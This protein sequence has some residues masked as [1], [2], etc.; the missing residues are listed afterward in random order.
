MKKVFDIILALN[1]VFLIGM[2][3]WHS[4]VN[5]TVQKKINALERKYE[6]LE[7]QKE[8]LK[9]RISNR[10]IKIDSLDSIKNLQNE[11]IIDSFNISNDSLR[12]LF[13]RTTS[14]R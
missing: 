9:K 4:I 8:N 6:R 10:Q 13:I 3:I 14:K 5:N 7:V 11:K 12:E 1:I 2:F